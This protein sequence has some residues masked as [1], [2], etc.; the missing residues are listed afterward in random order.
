M[1]QPW[2]CRGPV[3]VSLDSYIN[4]NN[5]RINFV[6]RGIA[7]RMSTDPS[8]IRRPDDDEGSKR[9]GWKGQCFLHKDIRLPDKE[10]TAFQFRLR[11]P[12]RPKVVVLCPMIRW[13]F[14][15]IRESSNGV[16]F[17]CLVFRLDNWRLNA[18]DR[19]RRRLD[20]NWFQI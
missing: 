14:N 1:T 12:Q 9:C 8:R 4:L 15:I 3:S 2:L 20:A 13:S 5:I 18:P 11:R 10:L 6:I 16:L 17:R 19:I 7:R